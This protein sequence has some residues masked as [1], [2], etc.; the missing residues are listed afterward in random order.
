MK[1]Q[2]YKEIEASQVE[3]GASGVK[4]RVDLPKKAERSVITVISEKD[5]AENFIMRV[6]E[7]EP[8]GYTPFH[9]H[10]WEHEVFVLRGKGIVISENKE[11]IIKEGDVIFIPSNEKHQFKNNQENILEVICLIPSQQKCNL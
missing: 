10:P 7:I 8:E 9:E 2:N 3:E 11:K 5:G 6:F 4:I 1:V